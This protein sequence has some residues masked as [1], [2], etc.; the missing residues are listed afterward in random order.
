MNERQIVINCGERTLTANY[1]NGVSLSIEWSRVDEILI[2]TRDTGPWGAD[3]WW[4]FRGADDLCVFPQGAVG[5]EDILERVPPRFSGFDQQAVI[6][7][8][9]STEN[10]WFTC[11]Q[12][13]LA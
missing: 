5:E 1:P 4:H 2:E 11:W 6:S 7:A 9:G 10:A 13:H 3:V 12:R 8:M